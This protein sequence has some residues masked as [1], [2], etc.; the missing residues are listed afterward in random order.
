MKKLLIIFLLFLTIPLTGC[1]DLSDEYFPNDTRNSMDEAMDLLKTY[2]DH[3]EDYYDEHYPN[4]DEMFDIKIAEGYVPLNA[5]KDSY[6]RDELVNYHLTDSRW[7]MLENEFKFAMFHLDNIFSFGVDECKNTVE[8]KYCKY[9]EVTNNEIMF[10]LEGN[11][12]FIKLILTNDLQEYT[13]KYHF[14]YEDELVSLDYSFI[15]MDTSVDEILSYRYLYYKEDEIQKSIFRVP[16]H[17]PG[18]DYIEYQ[19]EYNLVTGD[20]TRK[21]ETNEECELWYY[22]AINNELYHINKVNEDFENF[23]YIIFNGTKEQIKYSSS[24]A[25]YSINFSEISGWDY[26][27]RVND[28]HDFKMYH[29]NTL[30]DGL[31]VRI[32]FSCGEFVHGS[33]NVDEFENDVLNLS[34]YEFSFPY[35]NQFYIDKETFFVENFNQI[36]E[37]ANME[38]PGYD[39]V[40]TE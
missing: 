19:E 11:E 9:K 1:A 17:T 13:H 2:S 7:F 12:L 25:S 29:N 38:L 24:L 26:L 21:H 28:S 22:N 18:G 35:S 30:I 8:G 36:I 4:S 27:E 5:Y 15:G 16:N 10:Q 32:Q 33:F 20:Y 34:N 3:L 14:R 37:D 39:K 23:V 40:A 31:T 6:T